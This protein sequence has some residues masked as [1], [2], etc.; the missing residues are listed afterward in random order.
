MWTIGS[1]FGGEERVRAAVV[2]QLGEVRGKDVLELFCGT[3]TMSLIAA[4][5]GASVT[6]IDISEAMCAVAARKAKREVVDL[7]LARADATALPFAGGCFDG[8]LI[9]FGLHELKGAELKSVLKESA[10]VLKPGARAVILDYHR[11]EGFHWL[12][13]K[14]FFVFAET[15]TVY[16]WLDA[17]LQ[18]TLREAGF[19]NF[20]R[21]YLLKGALQAVS[22][23][24]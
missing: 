16:D 12:V 13:L 5:R 3:A 4:R 2:D 17:D 9:S 23:E 1:V 20:R 15:D 22:V 6:A 18:G 21:I 24:K 14:T 19:R 11:A 8:V 10:R 7:K